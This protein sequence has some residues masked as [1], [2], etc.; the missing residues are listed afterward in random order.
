MILRNWKLGTKQTAGFGLILL[1]MAGASLLALYRMGEVKSDLEKVTD[2]WLPRIIAV[3][4]INQST[5]DLRIQQL[6]HALA[7]DSLAKLDLAAGI[8]SLIDRINTSF[9]RYQELRVA[10]R[11][12]LDRRQEEQRWFRHFDTKWEE[13]QDISL[14]SFALSGEDQSA[15]AFAL[16]SGEARIVFDDFSAALVELVRINQQQSLEAATR[17]RTTYDLHRRFTIILLI[18]TL[19]TAAVIAFVL[20]R[21]ITTPVRRLAQAADQVAAGDLSV[22]VNDPGHDEIGHLA[23]AFDGMTASLAQARDQAERQSTELR[24]RHTELQ[25]AHHQ[26]EQQKSELETALTELRQTQ[27]QL[28]L[29]EKMASLGDLVAGVSHELN[30]PGGVVISAADISERCV[31]KIQETLAGTEL[32]EQEKLQPL[33]EMLR[34]N[35]SVMSEAAGRITDIVRSL[36]NFARLDEAEY[37]PSDIHDGL[38]SSLTLLG[39]QLLAEITV[40]KQFGT[41]PKINCYPARLNQV[42]YNLLKNAATAIDGPGSIRIVTSVEDEEITI[43]ITDT[44]RG[45]PADLLK[46]I[47][48]F[49]F[50]HG[51]ARVKM[52]SGLSTAYNIIGEHKGTIEIQSDLGQGATVTVRLPVR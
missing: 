47:F 1:L 30:N 17:A 39:G 33:L 27:E 40:E 23:R 12:S 19:T 13:Y 8:V 29:S 16:L 5:S 24:N 46:R 28:V 37:Q 36:R 18:V 2:D 21:A 11:D 4:E 32:P 31:K 44:G 42:F 50:G 45:I 7:T 3:S 15:A 20:A 41:L 38:E 14:E 25:D 9:D 10:V 49:G 52:S 34:N 48:E 43:R 26:L 6:Q 51:G 22:R 35:T